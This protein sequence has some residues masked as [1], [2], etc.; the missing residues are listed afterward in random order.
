MYEKMF[1]IS[2]NLVGRSMVQKLLLALIGN[3]YR[4]YYFSVLS[5]IVSFVSPQFSLDEP[6]S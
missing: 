5:V 3:F 1:S 6:F 4:E 2:C